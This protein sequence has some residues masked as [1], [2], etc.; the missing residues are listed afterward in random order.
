[1]A[2]P[3]RDRRTCNLS[4]TM[5]AEQERDLIRAADAAGQTKSTY[6]MRAIADQI[7]RDRRRRK[8]AA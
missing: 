8:I 5:T 6:A 2:K 3:A 1:M 7:Q 4:V